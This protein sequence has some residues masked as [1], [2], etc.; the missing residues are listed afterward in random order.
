VLPLLI[1]LLASSQLGHSSPPPWA[2][3]DT[4]RLLG[5]RYRVVCTGRG[6]SIDLA[7]QEAMDNCRIAAGELL[8]Q[9]LSVK[10]LTFGSEKHVAYHQ[11]IAKEMSFT[12]L[13][14]KPLH[15]QT[16]EMDAST[17]LWL[18]CEFDL[19]HARASR[20]REDSGKNSRAG[21]RVLT[22]AV[23]PRCSEVLVRGKSL[24]GRVLPC[25]RNPVSVLLFPD[26][27]E[28][29]VRAPGFLPKTITPSVRPS[30]REYLK[31]FM[32]PGI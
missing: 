7:R 6:P 22:M 12:G 31:V 3:Q 29:I 19:S 15:E 20:S 27:S 18:M 28:V 30:S 2:S 4:Q 32:E 25:G 8:E 24:P 21:N 26:D 9:R 23:V 13:V 5:S 14:C 1:S 11:E 10:Q 16:E 17:K